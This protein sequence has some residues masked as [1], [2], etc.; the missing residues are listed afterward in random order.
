MLEF[1]GP[2]GSPGFLNWSGFS[3]RRETNWQT[4]FI[5]R[6]KNF[7]QC[8]F[9]N[10]VFEALRKKKK[11][12]STS[13]D[14]LEGLL[15]RTRARREL[16][17]ERKAALGELFVIKPISI[18]GFSDFCIGISWPG[19]FLNSEGPLTLMS[20]QPCSLWVGFKLRPGIS[21]QTFDCECLWSQLLH[22]FVLGGWALNPK[23]SHLKVPG[24]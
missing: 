23:F 16:I 3:W 22:I 10:F 6:K 15:R 7:G 21:C 24:P 9:D 1:L 2:K 5:G 13:D 11:K 19:P 17:N 12:M 8:S 18:Y 20:P 4:S 14:E